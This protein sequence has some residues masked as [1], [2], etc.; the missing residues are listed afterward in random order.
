[1]N[2]KISVRPG[3]DVGME[4]AADALVPPFADER[5][6]AAASPDTLESNAASPQP[7]L[8]EGHP[9]ISAAIPAVRN[10]SLY[11]QSSLQ[12]IF[13]QTLLPDEVVISMDGKDET[14]IKVVERFREAHPGVRIVLCVNENPVGEW[15]NRR[16]AFELT[17]GE[18]VAML[19]DDDMWHPEFLEKAYG[20]LAAHPDCGFCFGKYLLIDCGEKELFKMSEDVDVYTGRDQ[21][22]RGK[23]GDFLYDILAHEAVPFPLSCTLFRRSLLEK[24]DFFPPYAPYLPDLALFMELAARSTTGYFLPERLARYRVHHGQASAW[25]RIHNAESKV[26]CFYEFYRKYGS[27]LRPKEAR[28]LRKRYRAAVVE[29]AISLLHEDRYPEAFASLARLFRLG[30]G[31][32]SWPRLVVMAALLLG[33]RNRSLSIFRNPTPRLRYDDE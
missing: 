12:S 25:R 14:S 30:P 3:G 33:I 1:M 28:L 4:E 8:K 24:A 32:P 19:D 7:R 26:D 10:R 16:K 22:K 2:P 13:R 17:T 20:C 27:T 31:L 5:N 23:Y 6:Q 15:A 29:H 18:F 21:L 9:L 11:L